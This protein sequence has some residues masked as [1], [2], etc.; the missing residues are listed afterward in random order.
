VNGSGLAGS[1]PRV[2][3]RRLAGRHTSGERPYAGTEYSSVTG[4]D[5]NGHC[6]A[7]I[8]CLAMTPG[9]FGVRTPDT[10]HA[11]IYRHLKDA[12]AYCSQHA[13]AL[14]DAWTTAGRPALWDA[15]RVQPLPARKHS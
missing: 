7:L 13:Q 11:H 12:K 14:L 2:T 10:R 8:T 9:E 3:F 4:V 15:S 1:A 5:V 6:V